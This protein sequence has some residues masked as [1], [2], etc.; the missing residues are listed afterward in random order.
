MAYAGG[1]GPSRRPGASDQ[2]QINIGNDFDFDQEVEGLRAHVGKIKQISL[3]IE[4]ER[5]Q[6][7]EIIDSLEESMERARLILSRTMGRLNVAWK[8]ARSNHMLVL[9]LSALLLFG[10]IYVF[11]KVYRVGRFVLGG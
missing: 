9:V 11:A 10:A 3:A 2:V 8:H 6:Q 1:A 5:K 4:E 7:G